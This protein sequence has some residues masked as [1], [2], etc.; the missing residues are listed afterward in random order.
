[1]CFGSRFG[2][3]LL[4]VEYLYCRYKPVSTGELGGFEKGMHTH[5]DVLGVAA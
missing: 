4:K 2:L 5:S 1:M 3:F